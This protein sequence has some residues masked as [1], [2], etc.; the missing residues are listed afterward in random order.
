M[1]WAP[2]VMVNGSGDTWSRNGLRFATK[3]EAESSAMNLALRWLLVED[4]RAAEADEPVNYR[5]DL[6]VGLV[7]LEKVM[8]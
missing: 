3:E 7:R 5:W 8:S 2:E 6:Q 1:S 4:F